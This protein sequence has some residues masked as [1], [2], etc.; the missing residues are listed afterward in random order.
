MG[1][2]QR[3]P[4]PHREQSVGWVQVKSV[5]ECLY[6]FAWVLNVQKGL[7][8]GRVVVDCAWWK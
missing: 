3:P 2:D 7:G 4:N 5:L 1:G 6:G 8:G